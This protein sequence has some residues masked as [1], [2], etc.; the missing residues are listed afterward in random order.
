MLCYERR[1]ESLDLLDNV[2]W[3]YLRDDVQLIG[4]ESSRPSGRL[5]WRSQ[6][7]AVGV[8]SPSDKR[9]GEATVLLLRNCCD[10]CVKMKSFGAFMALF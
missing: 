5:Q 8:P 9:S 10:V 2:S 1:V 3:R 4:P 6:D 7:L